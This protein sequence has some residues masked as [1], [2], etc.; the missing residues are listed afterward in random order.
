MRS[1]RAVTDC[2][3]LQAFVQKLCLVVSRDRSSSPLYEI[4]DS[5]P[6]HNITVAKF[7]LHGYSLQM[8]YPNTSIKKSLCENFSTLSPKCIMNTFEFLSGHEIFILRY[9]P[10]I[11]PFITLNESNLVFQKT[12]NSEE[13]PSYFGKLILSS[14]NPQ[15][16]YSTLILLIDFVSPQKSNFIFC[17][18]DLF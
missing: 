6:G 9:A 10:S 1:Q 16:I 17:P 13:F 15:D 14:E 3:E 2:P 4:Y 11:T 5:Q 18:A 8:T 7:H 12:T